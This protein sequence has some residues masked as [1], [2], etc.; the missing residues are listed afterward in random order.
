[1]I[2]ALKMTYVYFYKFVYILCWTVLEQIRFGMV[3]SLHNLG[4]VCNISDTN[5]QY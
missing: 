3:L 4:S 1:M 2:S 5:G